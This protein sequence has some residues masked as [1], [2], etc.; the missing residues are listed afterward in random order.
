MI[1]TKDMI[2]EIMKEYNSP[3]S[4]ITHM[5]KKG[6]IIRVR[7]GLYSDTS[8]TPG[9]VFAP[10]VYSPSYLSFQYALAYHGLIPEA[11]CNFTCAGFGLE[12]DKVFKTPFGVYVYKYIPKEVFYIEIGLVQELGYTIKVANPEKALC[13]MVYKLRYTKNQGD[14]ERYLY[15]DLRIEEQSLAS[16]QLSAFED[17]APLYRRETVNQ[18]HTIVKKVVNGKHDYF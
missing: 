11:V 5:I 3:Y 17:L 16:L 7:R 4:K 12:A 13:D 14:I 8:E 9:E 10:L 1:Y 15:Q 6:K 18:L 2:T